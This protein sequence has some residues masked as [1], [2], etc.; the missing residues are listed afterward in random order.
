MKLVLPLL[1]V[2]LAACSGNKSDGGNALSMALSNEIS[3]IDPAACYDQVCQAIVNTLYETPYEYE[4]LKRPYQ[5]R[6]L[7]ATE[8]PLIEEAG[9]KVT[10]RFKQDIPYHPQSFFKGTRL[11][12]AQDFANAIKRQA[13]QATRSQGWWLFEH[14]V[15]GLDDWRKKVANDQ[16]AFFKEPVEGLQTPDDHTLVI[17]LTKPFPQL[18]FALAMNFA[19]PVPEE[20][21]RALKNDLGHVAVGTGAYTLKEYNPNQIVVMERFKDYHSSTFPSIGDRQANGENMLADAGKKLPFIDKVTF[22]VQ[23]EQQTSWL[24]FLAGKVD[25]LVLTKDYYQ[26][27]LTAD[28]QLTAELKQKNVQM[29][30]A[31]TLIYWWLAF[32]MKDPVVGKNLKLRQAIAHGVDVE[33]FIKLFTNNVSQKANSIYPPGIPGYDPSAELPYKYDLEKAKKLLAEAGYPEGKGLA[34]LTFDVRGSSTLNRQIAEFVVQEI[35]ALGIR[36]RINANTFPVFLERSRRGELQFWHGGW[37]LDYPDAENILQLLASSNFPP[38]PNST[39]YAN[40]RVDEIFEKVRYMEEGPEKH[41]LMAEA[42]VEVHKDLPWVMLFYTRNYVL[43][44]PKIR[45]YRYSDIITNF[46][47]Y[48]RIEAKP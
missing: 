17:R 48:V 41:A 38:G 23:K 16:E 37:I 42:E 40:K 20:A 6:P 31:P 34:E 46:I 15:V 11:V 39:L 33:K 1:L 43:S 45:N 28:G 35:G 5:L 12:K 7:L 8:L 27:A 22:N 24:N 19:S 2:L 21:I 9:R 10:I 36:A 14:R 18:Q 47:K 13:F 29:Q 4:Y 25:I 30:V 44:Q 3:T 26:A 32:N